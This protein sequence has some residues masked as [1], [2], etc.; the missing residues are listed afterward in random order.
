MLPYAVYFQIALLFPVSLNDHV[1]LSAKIKVA[2]LH[3]VL[4]SSCISIGDRKTER[5]TV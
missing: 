3:G 2:V 4:Q 1:I 5:I